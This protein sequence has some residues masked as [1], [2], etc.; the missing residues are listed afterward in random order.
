M[1]NIFNDNILLYLHEK[2]LHISPVCFLVDQVLM[3]C[4]GF[5]YKHHRHLKTGE[6]RKRFMRNRIQS[7]VLSTFVWVHAGWSDLL[8]AMLTLGNMLLPDVLVACFTYSLGTLI[9]TH[10]Y[11]VHSFGYPANQSC[12]SSVTLVP[13]RYQNGEQCGLSDFD[14]TVAVGS[15]QVGL[16]ISETSDLLGCSHTIA[17]R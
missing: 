6:T 1:K 13:I 3:Y 15:R 2:I 17:S 8:E 14:W 4:T 16:S 12:S 9:G 11:L 10:A 7:V 5:E